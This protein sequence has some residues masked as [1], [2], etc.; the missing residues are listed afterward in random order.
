MLLFAFREVSKPWWITESQVQK[1]FTA[2]K[3]LKTFY[4]TNL[5]PLLFSFHVAKLVDWVYFQSL[6]FPRYFSLVSYIYTGFLKGLLVSAQWLCL[7]L[8]ALFPRQQA[9]CRSVLDYFTHY[10]ATTWYDDC[11]IESTMLSWMTQWSTCQMYW[12]VKVL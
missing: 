11:L 4:N 2:I 5:M 6:N 1:S 12:I 3:C 8:N 9:T 10:H 7:C